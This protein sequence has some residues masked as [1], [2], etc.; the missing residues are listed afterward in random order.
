[1]G[2]TDDGMMDGTEVGPTDDGMMDGTEVGPTDD[3]VIVGTEVGL[4]DDGVM[5]GTEVGPTDD[6]VMDGQGW[7]KP[8]KNI[9]MGFWV[10]GNWVLMGFLKTR[11]YFKTTSFLCGK[12]KLRVL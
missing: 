5:D 7:I 3:G 11:V 10:V 4:T 6:G 8:T 2:P 9:K 1:M 12:H